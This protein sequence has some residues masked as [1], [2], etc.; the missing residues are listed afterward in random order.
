MN[1]VVEKLMK[2]VA[3]GEIT[4]DQFSESVARYAD[5]L[6]EQEKSLAGAA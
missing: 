2:Q 3:D 5:G 1:P 4:L 6:L